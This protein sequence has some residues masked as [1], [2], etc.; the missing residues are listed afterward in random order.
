MRFTHD[1][2][3]NG[4]FHEL[5]VELRNDVNW[6]IHRRTDHATGKTETEGRICM[7]KLAERFSN[8]TK[9][10]LNPYLAA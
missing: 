3:E 1:D 6:I 8:I 5:T 7:S 10:I 9:S 2:R 4:F